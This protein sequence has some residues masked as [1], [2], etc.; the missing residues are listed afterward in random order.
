MATDVLS[1][2]QALSFL[3]KI[4]MKDAEKLLREEPRKFLSDLMKAYQA[5]L[6]FQCL[7]LLA[8]PL[9]ERHV[10]T[11]EEIVEAGMSME[12]GLCFT[13]NTFMYLLLR[14]LGFKVDVLDG[15]F[16]LSCHPH[17]HMV[18][19]LR[20]LSAPGDNYIVDIGG[21]FPFFE[22]ISVKD[23]PVTRYE[24]GLEYRY[25]HLNGSV[26]RLHRMTRE[27]SERG[28]IEVDGDWTQIFHFDLNPVDANFSR[29]YMKMIYVEEGDSDFLRSIRA[30]R[31]PPEAALIEEG[32]LPAPGGEESGSSAGDRRQ[33][34]E[35]VEGSLKGKP[36][37]LGFRD[38]TLIVGPMDAASKTKVEEDVWAARIKECFPTIPSAKVDVAVQKVMELERQKNN[39]V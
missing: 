33:E 29:P 35:G 37:M 20:D 22:I 36:T 30:V 17:T 11:Q 27:V 5:H 39:P 8:Q 23:L 6:P 19:L 21:G 15:S 25:Q 4:G 31:Y 9:E 26:V 3:A 32:L 1:R 13:L 14:A 34:K 7:S 28:Q 2:A 18:V 10:P 16:S 12:G 38:Q 24:A